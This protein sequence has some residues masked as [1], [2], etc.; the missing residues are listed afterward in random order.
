MLHDQQRMSISQ[1]ISYGLMLASHRIFAPVGHGTAAQCYSYAL[2]PSASI[3]LVC[4]GKKKR[5]RLTITS[6]HSTSCTCLC[7]V[8]N[9][10]L[11]EVALA[12]SVDQEVKTRNNAVAQAITSLPT[13]V[14]VDNLSACACA[15]VG[16]HVGIGF[17]VGPAVALACSVD[18]KTQTRSDS[19]V[20]VYSC[21]GQQRGAALPT[22]LLSM[23]HNQQRLSISRVTFYGS[24][25]SSHRIFAPV[26][27][28][29]WWRWL[30]QMIRRPRHEAIGEFTS[31][32]YASH[33]P[34]EKRSSAYAFV[35]NAPR[36]ATDEH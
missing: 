31:L 12:C 25:L 24:M 3:L 15:I 4:C 34:I 36:P 10:V 27:R 19:Y 22:R 21:T 2:H 30:A 26:G 8:C 35:V 23:F 33:G 7:V 20:N 13:R 1:V 29:C 17:E 32:I 11:C 28:D 18:Q 16:S 9:A 6:L 14:V 5:L